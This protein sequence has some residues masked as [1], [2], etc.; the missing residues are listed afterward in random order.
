M[1][2]DIAQQAAD[3]SRPTLPG[4]DAS[5]AGPRGGGAGA[6]PADGGWRV[7]TADAMLTAGA[8]STHSRGPSVAESADR[9]TTLR[10]EAT[11]HGDANKEDVSSTSTDAGPAAAPAAPRAGPGPSVKAAP[12][13]ES[14]PKRISKISLRGRKRRGS[15]ASSKRSNR[16][17]ALPAVAADDPRRAAADPSASRPDAKTAGGV[18]KLF[19]LLG[20]CGAAEDADAIDLD[21]HAVPSRN[22]TKLPPAAVRQST[23]PKKPDVSAAESS[24]AESKETTD[25]RIGGPPY[26]DLKSAGEPMVQPEPAVSAEA[27]RT[28]N[29]TRGD[30]ADP[31]HPTPPTEPA[32]TSPAK[33]PS[34]PPAV[35]GQADAADG[36]AAAPDPGDGDADGSAPATEPA[37]EPA[38]EEPRQRAAGAD[39]ADVDT[40]PALP[41]PPPMAPRRNGPPAGTDKQAAQANGQHEAQK[42]LLPPIRPEFQG[43]KCLVLDL[44]ETLVHSSFKVSRRR[45][46]AIDG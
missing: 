21:H 17:A 30:T 25:D 14:I 2:E 33:P 11:D 22:P 34:Q 3:A 5:H 40:T 24:T 41:P 7:R 15:V 19:A 36:P 20:C 42:W 29:R 37:A 44:D 45:R 6:L 28:A 38:A 8:G 39:G 27:A 18:A 32:R 1:S 16:A 31:P 35:A 10:E 9:T 46:R 4:K 13:R 26:A 43:K 12:P 23:P